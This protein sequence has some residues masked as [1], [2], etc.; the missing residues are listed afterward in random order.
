MKS[1]IKY[2]GGKG[3]FYSW[4]LDHRP[5]T[6]DVFIEPFGGS[7]VVLLNQSSPIEIYN[8]LNHNVYT[9]Y[10][11]IADKVLFDQFMVYCRKYPYSQEFRSDFKEN[12]KKT[13]INEVHRAFAFFYV[14]RTSFN[15]IGGFSINLVR[16]RGTSKNISDYWAVVDRLPDIHERLKRVSIMHMDA[17][18]LIQ[19]YDAP[20]VFMYLDPPYHTSTRTAARYEVDMT[21]E[22]HTRLVDF[23]L[24]AKS[25]VLL[26]G[27]ECEEYER[28]SGWAKSHAT[29]N[30]ISGETRKPKTK[31]ETLWYNYDVKPVAYQTQQSIFSNSI[32]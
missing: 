4:I 20:N 19:K 14:N 10:K 29:I 5:G 22:Q 31:K 1:P 32:S 30:T 28:L 11:V 17:F 24:S 27:Y 9:F 7:G 25:K 18:D 15:G 6:T 12:I 13:D 3:G 8:D 23:L 21:P 16:R 26:S 2:F